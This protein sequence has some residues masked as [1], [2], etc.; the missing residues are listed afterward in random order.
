MFWIWNVNEKKNV[1][2]YLIQILTYID[3]DMIYEKKF[4]KLL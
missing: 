3:N 2:C 1:N 4:F